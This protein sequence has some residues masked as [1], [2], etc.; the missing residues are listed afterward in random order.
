MSVT[1]KDIARLAGVSY[2]TVSKALNDSPLVQPTTKE[3]I[4]KIARELSYQP[5]IAAKKLVSNKSKTIGVV[6]PTINRVALS[7]IVTM[8]NEE[9]E[10]STYSMILSISKAEV[11]INMFK[12]FQVD[13]ILVFES[14]HEIHNHS[15][16]QIPITLIATSDSL[17][18]SIDLR[19]GDAIYKAVE[20]LKSLGHRELA[21]IGH[22][23]NDND[24]QFE[25]YFGFTEALIRLGLNPRSEMFVNT[26]GLYADHGYQAMNKLLDSGYRPTAIVS[27]SYELTQ[28]IIRATKEAGLRIPEDISLI[29]YD[30]I[31]QMGELEIPVTA[32]GVPSNLIA[33][34]AVEM[35]FRYI[36][37]PDEK[38]I[39]QRLEPEIC[40]RETCRAI[41]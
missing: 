26:E 12:Q 17:Y 22:L 19:R 27:G 6:W 37:H 3:K 29:G 31:P 34:T 36:D 18:P 1:I 33:K 23:R 32:V 21:Y 25:K 8:L 39:V 14:S 13:G 9:I 15:N 4:L 35:L 11:A 20:Y 7:T 2:S 5:N 40:I 38:P 41:E 24:G 10:K 28:G 30:H 16:T